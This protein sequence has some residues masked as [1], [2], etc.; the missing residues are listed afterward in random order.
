LQCAV[1][2]FVLFINGEQG[3]NMNFENKEER[4][5]FGRDMKDR[6]CRAIQYCA[7]KNKRGQVPY[8]IKLHGDRYWSI[9]SFIWGQFP[10]I[11]FTYRDDS[12]F[13]FFGTIVY[14]RE[15]PDNTLMG[16]YRDIKNNRRIAVESMNFAPSSFRHFEPL[17]IPRQLLMKLKQLEM[18]R[19][20]FQK[21]NIWDSVDAGKLDADI[22]NAQMEL[23][24]KIIEL[25]GAV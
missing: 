3:G 12:A 25:D 16:R 21:Q 19:E 9:I 1:Q 11:E 22:M 15:N 6:V 18:I 2:L 23:A 4:M 17:V 8:R 7:S 13:L 5:E 10:H 24:Q 20:N 14:T